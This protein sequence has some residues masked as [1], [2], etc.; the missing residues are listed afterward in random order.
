MYNYGE[1]LVLRH[2]RTGER[3]QV[4]Y[5]WTTK[6]GSLMVIAHNGREQYLL[7]VNPGEWA[8]NEDRS[9]SRAY[10]KEMPAWAR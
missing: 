3:K 1:M 7:C 8:V 9:I 5:W 4:V 10:V 2:R 6:R